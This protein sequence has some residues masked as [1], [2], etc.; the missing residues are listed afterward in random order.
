MRSCHIRPWVPM[1]LTGLFLRTLARGCVLEDQFLDSSEEF[2][3]ALAG[4][5]TVIAD[6]LSIGGASGRLVL[7]DVVNITGAIHSTALV[8]LA[9]S[10]PLMTSIEAPQLV[11]LGGLDLNSIGSIANLSFPKLQHVAGQIRIERLE[12]YVNI[13]FPVL[14]DVKSIY[15]DG[16]FGRL[17]FRRLQRVDNDLIVINCEGC[18][19]GNLNPTTPDPVAILFPASNLW[20]SSS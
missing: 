20:V 10:S 6:K 8:P 16:D 11:H 18:K 7:P 1:T 5:T 19:T 14:E 12:Q 4:C 17:G 3:E 2:Y 9:L 15:L 13:D